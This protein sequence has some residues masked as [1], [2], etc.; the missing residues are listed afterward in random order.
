MSHRTSAW[1]A[2]LLCGLSLVLTAPSLL[3]ASRV[4]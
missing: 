1:L 2:W 3:L 4:R